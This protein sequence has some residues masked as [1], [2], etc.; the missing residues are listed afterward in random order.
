MT[1]QHS[2][3]PPSSTATQLPT[4]HPSIQFPSLPIPTPQITLLQSFIPSATKPQSPSL[5][6]PPTSLL[7]SL[8]QYHSASHRPL[9]RIPTIS[10]STFPS[11][12]YP[13]LTA[14]SQH[15]LTQRHMH[16][17]W[18]KSSSSIMT[19]TTPTPSRCLPNDPRLSANG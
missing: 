5:T 11:T 2:T 7:E 10:L 17:P 8:I 16:P 12:T 14:S 19:R 6:S 13:P 9:P 18:K 1:Q 4:H 15:A 3:S